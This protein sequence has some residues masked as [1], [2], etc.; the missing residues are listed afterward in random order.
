MKTLLDDKAF[1]KL[2]KI[3]VGLAFIVFLSI[4]SILVVIECEWALHAGKSLGACLYYYTKNYFP[5]H[6]LSLVFFSFIFKSKWKKLF[7]WKILGGPLVLAIFYSLSQW[8]LNSLLNYECYV[9]GY[10]WSWVA[11]IT[12]SLLFLTQL[13]LYQRKQVDNAL[14]FVLSVY[15]VF[16]AQLI[17]E[18]PYYWQ[19]SHNLIFVYETI[20]GLIFITLLFYV[21]WRPTPHLIIPSTLIFLGWTTIFTLSYHGI[22]WLPRLTTIPLFLMFPFTLP[23]TR[24]EDT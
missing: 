12:W 15:G 5:F 19:H 18:I 14:S 3:W 13:I 11:I 17:Y 9:F 16:L 1:R 21:G 2:W 6:C 8:K 24:V 4:S 7:G 20:I 23:K 10:Q 22:A